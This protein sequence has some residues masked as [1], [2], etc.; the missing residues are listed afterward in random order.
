[1]ILFHLEARKQHRI[2]ECEKQAAR[3]IRQHQQ[4]TVLLQ[5]KSG[6]QFHG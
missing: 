1:M 3:T 5:D 2:H 4:S 6:G